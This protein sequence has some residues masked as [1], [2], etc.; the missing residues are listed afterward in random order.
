MLSAE[1][2]WRVNRTN[3]EYVDY[4]S[5][6]AS[7]SAP[8]AQV[9]I[10]RGI[11]SPDALSAFLHPTL[12]GFSDPFDL[13]DMKKAVSRIAAAGTN[14]ERVLIHGD[15]DA[16]GVTATAI[17]VE[18]LRK[19]GIDADYFIPNRMAHGYG[20]GQAGVEKA[21]TSGAKLI[22]TVDCGI[23]SFEAVSSANSLGIDVIITDH[24]EAVRRSKDEGAGFLLPEAFAI[25]N[26]KIAG[27]HSQASNLSGAGIA[28]KVVQ[29]LLGNNPDNVYSM[30]DLASLG[31]GA[32]VVPVLDD[33]RIIMKEGLKLIQSGERPGIK[34]LK[35][36]AGIRPDFLKISS[37]HYMLIPR[38]NAA[39][40]IADAA[41]VVKLLTTES[42]E[43]AER[44]AKWMNDM[45]VKRQAIELQVYNEALEKLKT[46]DTRKGAIVLASE[47]WHQGVVG[48]V[49]SRISEAYNRP[50]FVLSIENGIA[51]GS[52]RSIPSFDIHSGLSQ[53]K[54]ILSRFGGHKQAA[55]LSLKS[56]DVDRFRDMISGVVMNELSDDD[57][58]PV[59]N[60][61]AA[62]KISDIST[63][64][65]DELSML[66]PFGCGNEE[67][68]FGAKGLQISQPRVVGKNQ[69]HLKMYL[70]QNGSRIDS[71]GFDLGGLME[72]IGENSA[73]DAVFQ[74]TINIWDG[75]RYLQL[76]IKGIRPSNQPAN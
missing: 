16:D 13:P 10:N 42:A 55:G 67:P 8:F 43:E 50:A 46:M 41:D 34:A 47:G 48:I 9:L 70:R 69:N 1:Q 28:F 58:V 75:G 27:V 5:R 60:I 6:S 40:R 11:K 2:R 15:Y 37:L 29:G 62:V 19:T 20:F 68:L 56:E 23:T 53:C 73:I 30:M 59:L 35:A 32:D 74:P 51:K 22:I 25:I 24:H 18:G 76:N 72:S 39:G 45:N 61:D 36:V 21:N 7:V 49:A 71:I 63:V 33:N 14:G 44:L 17:M 12:A 57:F 54:D 65:V 38:I 52:A 31:T 26:P 4:L 66:E 3:T 64:L